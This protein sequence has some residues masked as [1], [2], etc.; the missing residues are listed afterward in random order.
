VALIGIA[1][2]MQ[3]L[4]RVRR[5]DGFTFN[6]DRNTLVVKCRLQGLGDEDA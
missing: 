3:N 5:S 2:R 4:R 1:V 6:R